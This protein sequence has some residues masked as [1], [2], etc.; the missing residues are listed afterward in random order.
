MSLGKP[1]Q[2]DLQ[3]DAFIKKSNFAV[4]YE[5][6][7]TKFTWNK[8]DQQRQLH[9]MKSNTITQVC[10]DYLVEFDLQEGKLT[11]SDLLLIE[12]GEVDNQL[13]EVTLSKSYQKGQISS[14]VPFINPNKTYMVLAISY[15]RVK[16]TSWL[17]EKFQGLI[18]IDLER[19]DIY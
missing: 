17:D 1:G 15:G 7:A 4:N 2:T 9:H 6:N 3:V 8:F 14:F 16:N 11:F 13:F 19:G 12:D 10:D 5:R 18:L